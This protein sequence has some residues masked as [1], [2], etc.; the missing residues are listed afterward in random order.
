MSRV[1]ARLGNIYPVPGL[2]NIKGTNDKGFEKRY[3]KGL[4]Q[5]VVNRESEKDQ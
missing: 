1:K 2:K 3:R 4:R 5:N